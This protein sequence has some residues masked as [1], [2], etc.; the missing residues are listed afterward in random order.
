MVVMA[1]STYYMAVVPTGQ[2]ATSASRYLGALAENLGHGVTLFFVISGYCITAACDS[3][4]RKPKPASQFFLRRFRRIF[5]PYWVTLLAYLALFGGAFLLG[6]N[7]LFLDP[8]PPAVPN[9]FGLTA[10]QWTGNLTLTEQWRHHLAG[11]PQLWFTG[12]AWSL[13]YE[14][15][16]YIVCGVALF[17]ARR[18]LF[19]C[20]AVITAVVGVIVGVEILGYHFSS[21]RG[22]FFDGMWLEFAAGVWVYYRL[23][24]VRSRVGRVFD[25]GLLAL[26]VLGTVAQL[27]VKSYYGWGAIIAWAFAALLCFLHR[28]DVPMARSR[29]LR[30]ICFC[31]IM[32]Y[33]LY[34]THWPFTKALSHLLYL[35]GIRGA[36]PTLLVTIPVCVAMAVSLAWCFHCL[37]ERRF[38]NTPAIMPHILVAG[39]DEGSSAPP[40]SVGAAP[41]GSPLHCVPEEP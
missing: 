5:P 37:V 18:R 40:G 12:Q 8:V 6:W 26:V 41:T 29:I 14:E 3:V 30:P 23:R 15:Q 28:W 33:S 10:L 11:S 24:Y 20:L 39:I 34:L 9:P 16:F 35:G 4:R 21:F 36:W 31:G 38:L 22:F 2:T 19:V 32:C 25:A 13:C 1:H 27:K 7:W 17:L